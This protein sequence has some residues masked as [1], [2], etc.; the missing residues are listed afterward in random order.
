M[1]YSH[2]IFLFNMRFCGLNN[3]E[4]TNRLHAH[5]LN[6]KPGLAVRLVLGVLLQT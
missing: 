1:L 5:I 2:H 6:S 3:N 4:D